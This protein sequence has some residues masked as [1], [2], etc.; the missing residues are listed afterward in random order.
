M[1]NKYVNKKINSIS[2]GEKK[3]TK[4]KDDNAQEA[5]E[6]IRPTDVLKESIPIKDK[7]TQ[8]ELKLYKLI[9]KNTV[10]SCM[11]SSL[12]YVVSSQISAP[13]N[14]IYRRVKKIYFWAGK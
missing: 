13:D 14:L 7:I 8:N 2:L 1:G 4:K 5:H 10:Q 6:A 12:Y 9:W 11:S 3:E